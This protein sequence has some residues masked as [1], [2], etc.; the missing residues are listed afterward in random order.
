MSLGALSVPNDFLSGG[1]CL[2]AAFLTDPNVD[3]VYACLFPSF[4]MTTSCGAQFRLTVSLPLPNSIPF[5]FLFSESSPLVSKP[6]RRCFSTGCQAQRNSSSNRKRSPWPEKSPCP[7]AHRGTANF[8]LDPVAYEILCLRDVLQ[9]K[10]R[11]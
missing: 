9:Q 4:A 6:V 8:S 5:P 2:L 3:T 11:V 1:R 7:C 10:L